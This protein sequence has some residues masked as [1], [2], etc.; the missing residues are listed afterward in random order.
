[1]A[2][3]SNLVLDHLRAIRNDMAKMADWMLTIS[4]EMTAIRQ[5]LAQLDR[6]KST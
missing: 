6:L 5:Y 1:M 3:P 2:E 4:A